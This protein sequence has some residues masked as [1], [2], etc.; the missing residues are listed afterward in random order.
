MTANR[1]GTDRVGR[2]IV[3]AIPDL[4]LAAEAAERLGRDGWQV[5]RAASG[6]EARRLACRNFPDAVVLPADGPDE[7]GWLTCAKLRRAQPQLRVLLV[8][9]CTDDGQRFAQF[10]GAADLVP[11]TVSPDELSTLVDGTAALQAV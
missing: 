9:D 3:L 6:S 5:W 7:S 11:P 2:T 1:I 10:V 4:P 8:G